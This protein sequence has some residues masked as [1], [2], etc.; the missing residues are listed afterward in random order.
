MPV[1]VVDTGPL[2][3]LFDA[4]DGNHADAV[5][6]VKN[7]GG[8]L[9]TNIAVITETVFMLDFSI[10]ATIDFLGWARQVLDIDVETP[11][12]LP[13]IAEIID[14]Y[15]DLPADFADASLVAL[16]ERRGLENIAT[17]DTD[18]NIY[19]TRSRRVLRNVFF[20]A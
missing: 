13:R 16:A 10:P 18:F 20:D 3:A 2:I 8:P 14:K 12:D 1:I 5:R 15:S 9:V 11:R 7:A 6:F 19:R 17:L 4:S